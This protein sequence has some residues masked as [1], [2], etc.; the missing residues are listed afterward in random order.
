MPK[1]IIV[2]DDDEDTLQIISYV[3]IE[4]G[5]EI[6]PANDIVSFNRIGDLH[7]DLIL[8]DDW[9]TDGYGSQLCLQL[10]NDPKTCHIPVILFSAND[11]IEQNALACRADDFIAKPFDLDTIVAKLRFWTK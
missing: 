10:K 8:L 11:N 5:Y 4:A 1:R 9:L 3:L 6:I 2:V 7:A